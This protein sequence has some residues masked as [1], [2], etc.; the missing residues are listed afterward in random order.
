MDAI[1]FSNDGC[2]SCKTWKPTF[3]RLMERYGLD[4]QVIDLYKNK[5][6]KEKYGVVGI[7]YTV[8]LDDEGNEVGSILGNMIEE[9]AIREIEGYMGKCKKG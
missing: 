1:L 5:E 4:Y 3:I 2:G 7:P 6:L 8:F 9:L